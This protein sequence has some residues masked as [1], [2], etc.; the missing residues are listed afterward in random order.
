MRIGGGDN[1]YIADTFNCRVMEAPW[2]S[3]TNWGISMSAGN[4]YTVAGRDGPSNCGIGDDAK[5]STQ[6]D[7][8]GPSGVWAGNGNLY[9]ADAGNNRVQEVAG[10]AHTEFSQSM[11][12]DFVYTVAGKWNATA[13][14]SGDGGIAD[15]AL[16][17]APDAVWLDGSG[18]LWIADSANN[19]LR[20]V[21]GSTSD[22]ST[23]AG[24]GGTMTTWGNGGPAVWAGLLNAS[25]VAADPDGDLFIA[26]SDN[27][28]VQEIAASTHTQFGIA[29]TAGDV[30]T[31]AGS[32]IGNSGTS[33]DGGAATSALLFSPEGVAADPAGNLYIA[34][35]GNNRVQ[36]VSAA[37]GNIATIAGSASGTAGTSGDGG[38]ATA[39]LLDG[40]I[41]VAVD[42]SGN[43]YIA[44]Y[45]NNRVQEIAGVTGTQRGVSMTAGDIYTVAGSQAGT[46]GYSGDGGAATAARLSTPAGVAVDQAGNLYIADQGND[47]VREVA[48]TTH[49]QWAKT[50]TA[51]DIY[52]IAGNINLGGA[53]SGDT[54][55][56][57]SAALNMPDS[58]STAEPDGNGSEVA[59]RTSAYD[60]DGEQTS[61]TTPDG[62]LPG[63]NPGNYTTV[64]AY[65]GDGL[66]TSVTQGGGAGATVT[67]RVTSY[68]YDANGNQTSV[69]DPRDFTSQTQVRRR[70]LADRDS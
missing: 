43:V 53:A 11:T 64:T 40:P 35:T 47:V 15:A 45:D 46:G 26:D 38:S 29:M 5:S 58:V 27:D 70:R 52:T 67:P 24:N 44:D 32:A 1:L 9:I 4:L 50:L 33:G 2:G 18:N 69:T 65:N 10:S 62:N 41:S 23:V 19:R 14:F 17:D 7:L 12:A 66:T 42:D 22:I 3:G 54:G 51:G 56:A 21:S 28:R 8:D 20:E 60:S 49:T 59:T 30:Y 39:A 37:T 31:V 48:S 13:G 36:E 34:D 68:G 55:P 57:T 61:V 63:A 16:M 6:S 25:D